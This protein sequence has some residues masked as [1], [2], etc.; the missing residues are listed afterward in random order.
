[1]P[2]PLIV[3]IGASAGGL[4][5]L[6]DLVSNLNEDFNAAIFVV[7][8][9]K[10]D[11]TSLLAPILSRSS[12]VPV[13]FAEQGMRITPGTIVIAPPDRHLL[14]ENGLMV[15][16]RGA[17]ENSS[18]PAIDP[19]AEPSAGRVRNR[20]QQPSLEHSLRSGQPGRRTAGT[21]RR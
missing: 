13:I 15:L 18:R 4:Q 1:M 2:E 9:T 11:G 20:H 16:R 5:A 14:V 19:P 8:H 17:R 21:V 6:T 3:V 10:T 7:V 12:P